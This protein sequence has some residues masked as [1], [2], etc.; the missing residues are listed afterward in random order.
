MVQQPTINGKMGYEQFDVE[1]LNFFRRL[2]AAIQNKEFVVY[3]QPKVSIQDMKMSG[4]E[5]LV[6]WNCNGQI[7]PPVKFIPF[8]ERTGLVIDIDFYVL[9][10]TCKKMR[11]WLDQ[12]LEMVRI[13]VNFSKYHFNENGVA[14][15][16]HKVI[17]SYNI[18]T[19][20][21]E[22][23]FTETAYHDKEELLE[24][25]VDKLKSYGI[26]SSIDDFGSGYSSLNLLQNMDFE[27]VKL[28]KSLLGKGVENEK[29]K[30]VISSIIHMAK[31]LE[32]EVLAEGVE[33]TKE[34]NLLKELKCDMV[35]G[36]LFDKPLPMDEFERRLKAKVYLF[37]DE[38][39]TPEDATMKLQDVGLEE[40]ESARNEGRRNV[41]IDNTEN[42]PHKENRYMS[43]E[44]DY[45]VEKKHK[46]ALI[47]G[48]ILMLLSITVLG[49]AILIG[50]H[51]GLFNKKD[52]AQETEIIYTQAEVDELV[53]TEV[54]K[55]EA[56]TEERVNKE[57]KEKIREAAEVYG[58]MA[59]LLRSLFPDNL[60]FINGYKFAFV[61]IDRSLKQSTVEAARFVTDENTG[62][63]YYTDEKGNKTSYM[64]IDVSSFQK[65]ID[66]PMVK[67]TGI[68]FA[69]IRVG[70]RGYGSDG[71]LAED[72]KFKANIEGAI[73]AGIPVGV[74][75]Y[76]QALDEAEAIEEAQF[77]L[78]LISPYGIKGPV[79]LDVEFA[80]SN[81]R[82]KDITSKQ[83]TNNII[84]F[85]DTVS[86]AG[87]KPMIYSDVKYF[88]NKMDISRLENYEKWY[89]NYNGLE[90]NEESS[91][92]AYNNPLMFPYEFSMWQYSNTGSLSGISGDVDFDVLFEKWW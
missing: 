22:V 27:V 31:E 53:E 75:F 78:D 32:M 76:T 26:K 21:I 71:N 69:I 28:D 57:Y 86:A 89:A 88:A 40:I 47:A 19:E 42:V 37:E 24:Y 79:I 6:R 49:G 70:I 41:T 9:E 84:A 77:V 36:F 43:F 25:T 4:A 10:E 44:N 33:T 3:F 72:S 20:Y 68:D 38:Q 23:E 67:S 81:E 51:G 50:I 85:C 52:T 58:G 90:V 18:P 2:L 11:E 63:M 8:C 74:Y 73:K 1:G 17:K 16:I 55:A 56:E 13:S 91:I 60:V 7:L 5:A 14:E 30:K 39:P 82:I 66:W 80:N 15:R 87:Y 35:Q 64:G 12:G 65:D 45:T 83:R 34:L 61:P 29:A 59:N 92:W 46:G 48:V 54:S 62:F